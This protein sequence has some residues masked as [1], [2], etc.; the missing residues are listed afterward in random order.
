[1]KALSKSCETLSLQNIQQFPALWYKIHVFIYDLRHFH[2]KVA[3]ETRLEQVI[4]PFYLGLPYFKEGETEALKSVVIQDK[5]MMQF[6]EES[7]AEM[8]NRRNKKQVSSGDFRVCAAH[9]MAPIFEKAFGIDQKRLANDLQFIRILEA[10]GLELGDQKWT[11][12]PKKSFN[13][14][15]KKKGNRKSRN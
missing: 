15:D 10:N 6:I 12:S 7:L 9:D 4:D 14:A 8:L 11:G 5:T 1:M 13:P 2:E 3:S